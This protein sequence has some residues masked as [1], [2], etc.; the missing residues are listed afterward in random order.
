MRTKILI[1]KLLETTRDVELLTY[2]RDCL[3]CVYYI[4]L[5]TWHVLQKAEAFVCKKYTILLDIDFSSCSYN[6]ES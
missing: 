6:C 5:I 3:K 4:F 2:F 1:K